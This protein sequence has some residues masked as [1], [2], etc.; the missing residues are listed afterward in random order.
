MT[1]RSIASPS[2]LPSRAAPWIL[3]CSTDTGFAPATTS[4]T[5]VCTWAA[6]HGPG[7][8]P[9]VIAHATN[10]FADFIWTLSRKTCCCTEKERMLILNGRTGMVSGRAP[11]VCPSTS[12]RLPF[13]LKWSRQCRLEPRATTSLHLQASLHLIAILMLR[14]ESNGLSSSRLRLNRDDGH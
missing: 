13:H 6:S 7:A 2:R 14:S 11:G 1:S 12:T 9:N 4:G 3:M 10:N 8:T 5:L